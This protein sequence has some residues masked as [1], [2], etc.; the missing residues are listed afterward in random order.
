[1]LYEDNVKFDIVMVDVSSYN[2]QGFKLMHDAVSK[3]ISVVLMSAKANA[4]LVKCAIEDGAFLFME[5]PIVAEE[6]KYLWQH[7]LREKARRN[8]EKR[9]GEGSTDNHNYQF[10]RQNVEE[11]NTNDSMG[12]NQ[13]LSKNKVT[14]Q[15]GRVE[16]ID[17]SS[18][19][20]IPKQCEKP[21]MCTEWTPEL[22]DKFL[23]AVTQLGDG[24]CFPKDILELMN[25]PGLTRMQVASHLQKCR[26][27]SRA[28]HERRPRLQRGSNSANSNSHRSR[29]KRYGTYPRLIQGSQLQIQDNQN[30]GQG[31]KATSGNMGY[32]THSTGTLNMG[33][34]GTWENNVSNYSSMNEVIFSDNAHGNMVVASDQGLQTDDSLTLLLLLMLDNDHVVSSQVNP[35]TVVNNLTSDAT[36]EE[37]EFWSS[38]IAEFARDC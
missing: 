14:C 38:W 15:K 36:N 35:T 9:F 30:D 8:Q 3:D 33:Q 34:E 1:M 29:T 7:V 13:Y 11:E 25:V 28:P 27:G 18:N 26:Y 24:K 31:S 22:H 6:L 4:T 2:L 17:F 10:R 16:H 5:K 19:N 32:S 20:N 21:K 37:E 23:A 12:M